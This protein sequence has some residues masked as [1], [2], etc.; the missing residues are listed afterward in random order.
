MGYLRRDKTA[1][2]PK[3]VTGDHAVESIKEAKPSEPGDIATTALLESIYD[4]AVRLN[5]LEQTE[6]VV[7][8][9]EDAAAEKLA[10][11][12]ILI[13]PDVEFPLVK[14]M[15]TLKGE[16]HLVLDGDIIQQAADLGMDGFVHANGFDPVA[17]MLG[18][19]GGD[20]RPF[21][22]IPRLFM[23][24]DQMQRLENVPSK[25]DED[26]ETTSIDEVHVEIEQMKAIDIYTKLW[27]LF[28]YFPGVDIRSFL[29]KIRNRWTKRPVNRAIRWVEC[30][31]I[32][33]GLFLLT[34]ESRTCSAADT[35]DD[36]P[37]PG[38]I[39]NLQSEDLLGTGLDCME[40]AGMVTAYLE[41]KMA[42]DP[43]VKAMFHA[44][45]ERARHESLKFGQL[46]VNIKNKER[47]KDRID[48]LNESTKK[49][50]RYKKRYYDHKDDFIKTKNKGNDNIKMT[51]EF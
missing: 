15:S 41:R 23:D 18:L 6:D 47:F 38:E 35:A 37:D 14:A 34:G 50:P 5:L 10:D 36:P 9:L 43:G 22:P 51:S 13:D 8:A 7:N 3:P 49:I 39:Y 45:G 19:H 33:P 4:D 48:K 16:P 29:K 1:R 40:A 28:Q 46:S 25:D 30:N 2:P 20:D 11:I 27:E 24:C 12:N 44:M 26:F 21:V 17:A 31:M 42:K 32:N